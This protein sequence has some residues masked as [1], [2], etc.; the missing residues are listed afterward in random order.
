MDAPYSHGER[1]DILVQLVQQADGLDDH[2]VRPMD[3][4]L[5][6]CPGI[7]VPKTQLSLGCS[8]SRQPAHQFMEIQPDPT[9][10]LHN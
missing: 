3:I 7:A 2:V 1:V 9:K 8:R 10:Q 4:E 5:D 6:L